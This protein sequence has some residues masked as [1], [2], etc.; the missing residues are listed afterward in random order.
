MLR[1]ITELNAETWTAVPVLAHCSTSQSY[2]QPRP[3]LKQL[4]LIAY[5]PMKQLVGGA[6]GDGLSLL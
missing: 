2:H 1:S 6:A 4:Q 5:Q 3:P